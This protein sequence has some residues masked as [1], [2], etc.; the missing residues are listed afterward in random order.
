MCLSKGGEI[1]SRIKNVDMLRGN[2]F[3][4]I[5][6]FSVPILFIGLIQQLFNAVD[7]MVLGYLADTDAVA[8]VGATS[9]IIHLLTNVALGVSSGAKII[10]ARLMGEGEE[11][12]TRE[13]VYTSMVTALVLGVLV[14]ILGMSL[15][16]VFLR[17]TGCPS[18]I[19]DAANI[20][21][22]IY[23]ASV[24]AMMIYNFGANI[25]QVSGDSQRPL[26]YMILSG[27]LNVG[28]NLLLC[29]T[30]TDKVAAVAIATAA[31]Q[32]LGAVLVVRRLLVMNGDCR[33]RLRG[34]RFSLFSFG[35]LMS[36]G[37]PI[38]I[39]NSLYSL[40][41]LQIQ[42][43]INSFDTAAIA[44][45]SATTSLENL[46]AAVVATP[47]HTAAGVFVGKNLGAGNKERVQKSFLYCLGISAFLSILVSATIYG[48]SHELVSLYVSSE[49]AISFSQIRML[50]TTLPYVLA[51]TNGLLTGTIQAFGYSVFTTV[52]SIVSVLGFR[53]I[54]MQFIYPLNPTFHM[55]MLCF[56]ISWGLVFVVNL[57]FFSYVYFGKFKRG[58]I[59]KI[60]EG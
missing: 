11:K 27:L 32:I 42:S 41:N 48:F 10:L 38:G 39:T 59:K 13:T 29:L 9:T 31:S 36:N 19:F 17:L 51:T 24:P 58:K 20:Y 50:F 3:R 40:A 26:Y 5:I 30:L 28:L 22:M 45:N 12:K 34:S 60:G 44:G 6:S 15:S 18:K 1:V 33:L 47:W 21:M 46:Q 57:A 23:F 7:I 35:K 49:E 8:S 14:G 55:L 43:S 25:L 54:W 53:I 4:S 52:N 56:L 16:P 37:I 2:L